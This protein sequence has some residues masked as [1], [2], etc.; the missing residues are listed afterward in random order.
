MTGNSTLSDKG[1]V[2]DDTTGHPA[3]GFLIFAENDPL[4]A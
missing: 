1:R 3:A 2:A 4:V